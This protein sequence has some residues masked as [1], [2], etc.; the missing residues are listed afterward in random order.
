MLHFDYG[1]KA[2]RREFEAIREIVSKLNE[3][4]ATKRWGVIEDLVVLDVSFM[5]RLWRGAQLV[6]DS[7]SVGRAYERT[8]V[9]PVRNI[10]MATIAVAYAYTLLE[11]G[12]CDKT[13]VVLGS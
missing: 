13:V 8:V 10:V 1:Q 11:Q 4:A 6:D 7:V 3:V 2:S 9:V 5:K 12:L